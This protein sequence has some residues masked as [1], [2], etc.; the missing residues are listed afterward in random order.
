MVLFFYGEDLRLE[1]F[2]LWQ[3]LFGILFGVMHIIIVKVVKLQS[4]TKNGVKNIK[5]KF[6]LTYK[7]RSV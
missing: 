4:K 1:W 6:C 7:W 3:V 2:E 5:I